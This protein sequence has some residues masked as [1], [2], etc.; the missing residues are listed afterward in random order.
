MSSVAYPAPGRGSGEKQSRRSFQKI[1]FWRLREVYHEAGY[2]D[3]EVAD[4]IG[5]SNRTMSKRMQGH[6]PWRGDEI[7]AVC[8]LVGIA[9]QD[10]GKY[11]FP[12]METEAEA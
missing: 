2:Y 6:D 1:P 11:F 3:T 7:T 12:W 9:Q 8:R 5:M 10:V 4:E